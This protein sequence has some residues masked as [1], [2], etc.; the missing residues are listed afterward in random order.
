MCKEQLLFVGAS[1]LDKV[2]MKAAQ[3]ETF[4]NSLPHQSTTARPSK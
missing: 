4:H 2:Q 1:H 3:I